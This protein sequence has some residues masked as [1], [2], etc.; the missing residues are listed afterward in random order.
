M[1]KFNRVSALLQP[2]D[3]EQAPAQARQGGIGVDLIETDFNMTQANAPTAGD[4]IGVVAA[5][6]QFSKP[7]GQRYFKSSDLLGATS[8][9]FACIGMALNLGVKIVD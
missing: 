3:V 5:G 6:E 1:E 4:V 2:D 7:I 9:D 8:D